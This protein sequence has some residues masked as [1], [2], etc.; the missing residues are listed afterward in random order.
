MTTWFLV[1]KD[2]YEVAQ[3]KQGAVENIYKYGRGNLAE[4]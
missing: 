3:L 1:Q 2:V 4:G